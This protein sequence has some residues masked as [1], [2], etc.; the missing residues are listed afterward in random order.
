ALRLDRHPRV[1]RGPLSEPAALPEGRRGA[2]PL[3]VGRGAADE[4]LFPPVFELIAEVFYKLAG[5][6]DAQR[7]ARARTLIAQHYDGLERRLDERAY[8]CGDFSVAD[9]GYFL[10]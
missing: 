1:P 10:T 5:E 6:R 7:I 4:I 2:G 3:P 9:I 8:L